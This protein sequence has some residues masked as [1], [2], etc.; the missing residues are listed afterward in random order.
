MKNYTIYLTPAAGK[1]LIAK[2]LCSREDVRDALK[3]HTVV[4][5]TGSTNADLAESLL[6]MCGASFEKKG[7]YRGITKPASAK[8]SVPARAE[9]VVIEKG[10]YKPGLTIFDVAPSLKEGDI[11]FKGANALHLPTSSCG[12]LIGHP[13]AGTIIPCHAALCGRR[14]RL[15]HPVGLEKRVDEPISDLAALMNDPDTSGP[16]LFPSAGLPYTELDAIW[17]LTGV[18]ATLVAAGGVCGYEGGVYLLLEGSEDG[19]ASMKEIYD[20]VKDAPPYEI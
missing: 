17:D 12:I 1:K 20:S 19:L 18:T 3:N 8:P 6:N 11:I 13:E 9:D 7:F 5:I 4:L 14:V 16:R 2:A 15:I 10:V